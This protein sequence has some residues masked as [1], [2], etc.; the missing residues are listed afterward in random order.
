MSDTMDEIFRA[1]KPPKHYMIGGVIK[2]VPRQIRPRSK[3][4][5]DRLDEYSEAR[6][7]FM[8][9]LGAKQDPAGNWIGKCQAF[10]HNRRVLSIHHK[11]GRLGKLLTDTRYFMAVCRKC[12]EWIHNNITESRK[13]GWIAQRGEWNKT[14]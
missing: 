4:M 12:H 2:K 11:R 10:V 9:D 1:T 14:T 13:R 6:K 7:A 5:W 3:R 8:L